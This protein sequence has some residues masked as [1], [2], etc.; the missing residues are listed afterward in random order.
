[1]GHVADHAEEFQ[2]HFLDVGPVGNKYS[3]QGAQ[4]EQYVEEYIVGSLHT[5]AQEILGDGQVA[6]AGDRQKFCH[7]LDDPQEQS[8]QYGHG[9]FS[10]PAGRSLLGFISLPPVLERVQHR[11]QAVSKFGQRVFHTGRHLGIGL[12]AH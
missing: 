9:V 2:H 6:G 7:A 5:Q 8:V 10:P 1:M 3:R 12:A 11:L 4:M